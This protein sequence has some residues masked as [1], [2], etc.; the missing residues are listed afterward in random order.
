[1]KEV[2]YT[3]A[4][5]RDLKKVKKQYNNLDNLTFAIKELFANSPLPSKFRD[6]KLIGNYNSRRECHIK[7]DL[8]LIYTNNNQRLTLERLGSHSDLFK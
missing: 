7:P 4:F 5:K 8:L 2:R 1:M 3:N 6:H